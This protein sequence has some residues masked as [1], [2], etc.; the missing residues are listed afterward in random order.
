MRRSCAL[1][2][3]A[4]ALFIAL[5]IYLSPLTPNIL[6]L[7]FTFSEPAFQAVLGKWQLG[8]ISLYRSHFPADFVLLAVYGIFGFVFGTQFSA[9]H[10]LS[11]G[12]FGFLAW[13][14]PAAATA[15]AAENVLHLLL[16]DGQ[17]DHAQVL[18][19]LSGIAASVK[20]LAFIGF[21]LAV[22]AASRK[23]AG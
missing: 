7:Q 20:W 21:A 23:R 5:S 22:F 9:S 1:G 12:N 2:V 11:V 15:D 13:S 19:A 6:T 4:L 8:G 18:Y 17:P 16:T 3:L 14:L 10:R